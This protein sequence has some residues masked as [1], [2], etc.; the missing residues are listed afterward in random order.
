MA[1]ILRKRQGDWE[2]V[3]K[4]N[5]NEGE[6]GNYPEILQ[7]FKDGGYAAT[8]LYLNHALGRYIYIIETG[9]RKFAVKHILRHKETFEKSCYEIFA[10]YSHYQRN[11]HLTAKAIEQGC[12][13][14]QDIFLVAERKTGFCTKEIFVIAE[15]VEGNILNHDFCGEHER[16]WL[17]AI[18]LLSE[19]HS[20][21]LAA[22]DFRYKNVIITPENKHKIIDLSI[23]AHTPIAICQAKDMVRIKELFNV[24]P[25]E[26]MRVRSLKAKIFFWFVFYRYQAKDFVRKTKSKLKAAAGYCLE[27]ED[28]SVQ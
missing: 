8:P 15:Y 13:V 3:W 20:Y 24:N 16:H 22:C 5:K 10:G 27:S 7:T 11:F 28:E 1:N 23:S 12:A 18:R 2:I 6:G 19:L 14:V 17:P 4:V 9:G 26:E 21:G 25:F